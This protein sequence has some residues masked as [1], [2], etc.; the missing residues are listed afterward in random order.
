MFEGLPFQPVPGA[1]SKGKIQ[2]FALSTCGFCRR[3]Q[4]FLEEHGIAYEFIHLDRLSAEVKAL[5]KEQF[6]TAFGAT[7]SYPALVLED[8]RHVVGYVKR[9]WEDLLGLPHEE[10]ISE[11][12]AIE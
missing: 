6:K 7:L 5:T 2:F 8:G 4:D 12:E 1:V 3:G 11:V 9:A 10:P